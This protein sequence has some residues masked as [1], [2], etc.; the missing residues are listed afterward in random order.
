MANNVNRNK[1]LNIIYKYGIEYYKSNI[2]EIEKEIEKKD[3]YVYLKICNLINSTRIIEV[4]NKW[5]IVEFDL[6]ENDKLAK[7]LN[8][9]I[10]IKW[11]GQRRVQKNPKKIGHGY[12]TGNLFVTYEIMK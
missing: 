4:T 1:C 12:V 3:Y 5:F 2:E 8:N 9:L 6:E 10:F 11:I 7:D